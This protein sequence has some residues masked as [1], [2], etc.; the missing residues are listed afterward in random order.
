MQGIIIS[1]TPIPAMLISRES[2]GRGVK[3]SLKPE[4]VLPVYSSGC[5]LDALNHNKTQIIYKTT[6]VIRKDIPYSTCYQYKQ[7][8]Q[9]DSLYVMIAPLHNKKHADRT[10]IPVQT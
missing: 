8:A 3:K 6:H 4:T 7:E 5:M 9:S 2:S 1:R 10:D